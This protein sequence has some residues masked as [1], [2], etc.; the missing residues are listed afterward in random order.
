MDR[1]AREQTPH[2]FSAPSG[3]PLALAGLWEH[4]RDPGGG[5]ELLSATIIVG[6][7]ND[8]MRRFH[9][10]MPVILDWRDV[11]AWLAG[12]NPAALP[13]SPPDDALREWVVSTRVNKAGYGDDD[14]T[15]VA[16]IAHADFE[17][18]ASRLS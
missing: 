11:G 12:E 17:R 15:L 8:W 3:Q 5:E 16:R 13:H 4:W 7:A 10:R 6:A 18:D 14:A 1:R 2:Y 9:E